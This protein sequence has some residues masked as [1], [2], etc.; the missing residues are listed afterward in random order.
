MLWW[1]LFDNELYVEHGDKRFGPYRPIGGPIPLHRYRAHKK[2]RQERRAEQVEAL[3][4]NLELPRAAVIPGTLPAAWEAAA[5]PAGTPVIPFADPDPFQEFTYPNAVM[6][7]RAV[8]D[9]LGMP[10]AKLPAEQ[11]ERS[12]SHP[13]PHL[14]QKRDHGLGPPP[15][16]QRCKEVTHMRRDIMN[17]YGITKDFSNAGFYET[18]QHRQIFSELKSVLLDG[19]LVALAGIVGSGKTTTITRLQ[20]Q[21]AVE[22]NILVAKSLSVDKDRVSLSTLMLALFYDL[23]PEKDFVIP[24]QPEK[25]ERSLRDLLRKRKKPVALFIDEGHDLKRDTMV[26]LKRLMEVVR[27]AAPL[28]VVLAGH[29]KL[30]N[31]LRRSTLEEIGSRAMVFSLDN[32]HGVNR[33]YIY[34]LLKQCTTPGTAADTL[35]DEEAVE[36]FAESLKTPLQIGKHLTLALEAA[37]QIGGGP[38]SREVAESVLP[39]DINDMQATLVRHGYGPKALADL[40]SINHSKAHG[41]CAARCRRRGCRNCVTRC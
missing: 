25:R 19:H 10:L 33:E 6:A 31:E 30:A 21:L 5:K 2:T 40:L 4:A 34:W 35:F 29:P 32:V 17:H 3:A 38:V 24:T 7:K 41:W 36:F 15:F 11:I 16:T 26:G 37:F 8:A 39:R 28:S 22:G 23:G 14:K 27:D 1:G 9:Y 12:G 13:V 18:E 20:E